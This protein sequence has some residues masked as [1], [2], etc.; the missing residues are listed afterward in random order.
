[1]DIK[2]ALAKLATCELQPTTNEKTTAGHFLSGVTTSKPK[3]STSKIDRKKGFRLESA[4][5][6]VSKTAMVVG[7][8]IKKLSR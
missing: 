4:G 5:E 1:M 6:S 2:A 7:E 3:S 8:A